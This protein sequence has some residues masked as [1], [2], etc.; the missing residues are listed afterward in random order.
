[1]V[2]VIESDSSDDSGA[3][4]AGEDDSHGS[5]LRMPTFPPYSASSLFQFIV[6]CFDCSQA[7]DFAT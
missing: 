5:V 3:Q 2:I 4:T 1:M 6:Q 7:R